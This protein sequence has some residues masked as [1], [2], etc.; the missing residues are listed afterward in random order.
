MVGYKSRIFLKKKPFIICFPPWLVETRYF[1]QN[2]KNYCFDFDE[3][4]WE[5]ARQPGGVLRR[6]GKHSMS[7]QPLG[8]GSGD[9]SVCAFPLR[10]NTLGLVPSRDVHV[11]GQ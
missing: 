8:G 1:W 4:L 5:N 7:D 10:F 3:G 2:D 9:A 11:L 6:L